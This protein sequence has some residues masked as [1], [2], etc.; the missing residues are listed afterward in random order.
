[1]PSASPK[2]ASTRR[3]SIDI[4]SRTVTPH[5]FEGLYGYDHLAR[6]AKIK[7]LTAAA[8]PEVDADFRTWTVR[9]Q[10]RASSLPTTRP[11]RAGAAN[12]WPPTTSTA[13]SASPTRRS[14]SPTW[15][16]LAQQ[17]IVGLA[18][19]APAGAGR[20]AALRLR[21]ADGRPARAGPLHD[22]LPAGRSRAR[23]S[24]RP[25]PPATCSARWRARWSRPTATTSPPTRWAPGR[26]AWRSGG[27]AR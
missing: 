13:S 2:P 5:I 26:S 12:W 11:S 27:A 6:P 17:G 4:Y 9:L 19:A 3:R 8:M 23:V 16:S 25:W 24:W 10:A 7:P 22:P 15:A 1:M 20:Q 21:H 14:K 18:E